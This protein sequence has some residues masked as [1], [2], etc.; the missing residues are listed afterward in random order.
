MHF[1]ALSVE[2]QRVR[3][4]IKRQLNYFRNGTIR[5]SVRIVESF[6]HLESHFECT[7]VHCQ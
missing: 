1:V 4:E 7:N 3:V 2:S 5:L 6:N